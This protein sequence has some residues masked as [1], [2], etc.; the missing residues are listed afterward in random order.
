MKKGQEREAPVPPN[1]KSKGRFSIGR[2]LGGIGIM[3]LAI[4]GAFFWGGS[5][6]IFREF[7]PITVPRA[8]DNLSGGE[9]GSDIPD[10]F[11]QSL[12]LWTLI[13]VVVAVLLT[14]L[15]LF[16][17]RYFRRHGLV[18]LGR[19]FLWGGTVVSM[20]VTCIG[21]TSLDQAL[22][23]RKWFT[24]QPNRTDIAD[25]YVEPDVTKLP[26][27]D[28]NLVL[29]FLEAMDDGLGDPD[30]VEGNA[31]ESLQGATETWSSIENMTQY[32]S[33]GWSQAG[34][35]ASL[36]GVPIR[37]ADER[38][39]EHHWDIGSGDE[40]YMPGVTCLTDILDEAGYTQVYMSGADMGFAN[41]RNFLQSHGFGKIREIDEW[42]ENGETEMGDWGL[43]DRRL[44]SYVREELDAL[45]E[46]DE[47]FVLSF[48]TLDDHRPVP[49]FPYCPQYFSDKVLSAVKCQSDLLQEF[50]SY[51]D[52]KG[53]LED[54]V[55][56][57]VAD[58]SM[59]G[60][61]SPT[62]YRKKLDIPPDSV[63]LFNRFYSPDGV[64]F[65]RNH[66]SQ[67]DLAPTI[68]EIMGGDVKKGRLGLGVSFFESDAAV[69]KQKTLLQ[70][71]W[72][73]Q[74]EVLE[75][76]SRKWVQRIWTS[77]E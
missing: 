47:P 53:Y 13:P 55:V 71:S 66:G 52:D 7:G 20:V 70:L 54:T 65:G 23:L 14:S 73:E 34:M 24:Q 41:S 25:Y 26:S 11:Y 32:A 75:S 15:V 37:A 63:P 59:P 42:R 8:L 76:S 36:C 18:A 4:V 45:H 33:G 10:S 17:A 16:G 56:A 49:D 19:T 50:I 58:H 21:V 38:D 48:A 77:K 69:R 72:E 62:E 61:Y 31:L 6:W 27:G 51:M 30:L 12:I 22:S 64:Q 46:S 9:A 68:L 60:S 1:P 43:S 39:V 40:P 5:E 2:V 35:V 67:L 57:L 29:I 74:G 3:L 44:L 28:K